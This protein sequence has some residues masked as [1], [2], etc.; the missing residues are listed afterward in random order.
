M[1]MHGRMRAWV[2]VSAAVALCACPAAV[3]VGGV[4][5]RVMPQPAEQ[6][7][8]RGQLPVTAEFSVAFADQVDRRLR[9][10]VARLLARWQDRTGLNFTLTA[11]ARADAA[12]L[13]ITC[14]AA[15]AAVPVLGE[16]ESYRL[17][18]TSAGATLTAATTTGGL[19]GLETLSQLLEGD[20]H[21]FYLPAV[22]ID[23]R[24]RFPWRGLMIDV[25]R[26]WQPIEVIKRNLDAMAVVK[27]NVL[28]LHLTDDQGF[29]V[30][31]KRFPELT[32]LASDG[33]YFTREQI[34][35]IITYAA[36]RGIRVVPEFDLPGHAQAWAV[37]H[38]EFASGPGPYALLRRWETNVVLDP[39]NEELYRFLNQFIGEMAA[40]F[41]DAYIHVGGDENN[42]K[43]WNANPRIQQFIR[44]HDLK[45]NAGLQTYFNQRLSRILA[46][47][48][49]RMIGWEEI[50]EPGLPRDA[51]VHSWRGLK[52]LVYAAQAGY[53]A[54]LSQGYYLDLMQSAAVHYANDPVPADTELTPEEQARVLGG[55]A[56]MWS[57]WVSPETIDSRIWPRAA[58]IAERLWS[59]REVTDVEDMYRRLNL[60][61]ARLEEAG[62]LHE[63]WR[64]PMLRR[65]VGGG[66]CDPDFAALRRFAEAVEP[67]KG[68]L[69]LRIQ[70]AVRQQTPLTGFV[71]CLSP[72]SEPAR[73]FACEVDAFLN[74]MAQ[75]R[76]PGIEALRLQLQLWHD[77]A[78]TVAKRVAPRHARLADV[79]P[80]AQALADGSAIGL[81]ALGALD[82]GRERDGNWREQGFAALRA[83]PDRN[84]AAVLLP[85]LPAMRLLVAAATE[86]RAREAGSPEGWLTRVR[87]AAVKGRTPQRAPAPRP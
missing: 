46:R 65:L 53:T 70:T 68:Y 28:H 7:F 45:S 67:V 58:A 78:A 40:L 81:Q 84:P 30:E 73:R 37:A 42:G 85:M 34:S 13:V 64:E 8:G 62:V 87:A 63:A 49:K 48:G 12:A 27:L 35:E 16:N 47:H 17:R 44:D 29:R 31:S 22:R 3:A 80:V 4:Q 43:Q 14:E 15:A 54:V 41:P 56:A 82:G 71:D 6:R 86:P 36:D 24:P 19:R 74:G 59:P 10:G 20:A 18:I 26:H 32:A 72:E 50:L 83:L 77:A 33:Q 2:L 79:G 9:A 39:T 51:T 69:R 66:E 55:E 75:G 38:P 21:G 61:S 60:V 57:E 5:S 25:A 23:D 52:S 1:T 11:P 76:Q